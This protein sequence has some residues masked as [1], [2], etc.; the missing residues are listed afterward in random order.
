MDPTDDPKRREAQLDAA[1]RA[2]WE[3]L[4]ARAR[5]IHCPEHTI[6]PWRVVIIGET[7]DTLRL[8]SYGCCPRL[9]EAISQMVRSD[10]RVN[11]PR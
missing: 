9:G 2:V 5:A 1:A 6:G 10:P 7:R 8:H 4:A 11:S 3:D